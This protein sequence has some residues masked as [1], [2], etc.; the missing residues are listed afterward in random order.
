MGDTKPGPGDPF[1]YAD[2]LS[3]VAENVAHQQRRLDDD[4][5]KQLEAYRPVLELARERGYEELG[6]A[7][8]PAAP[9]LEAAEVRVNVYLARSREQA[10]ALKVRPLNLG[11]SRKYAHTEFVSHGVEMTVVR[12]PRM[13]DA[14]RK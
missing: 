4:Y 7:L 5:A 9:V 13:P 11:F 1:E 6:R 3:S 12:V 10:F 2:F 8:A 14:G